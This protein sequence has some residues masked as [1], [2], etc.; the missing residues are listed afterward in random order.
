MYVQFSEEHISILTND[1]GTIRYLY[2][3][4]MNFDSYLVPHKILKMDCKCEYK[5]QN[6]KNIGKIFINLDSAKFS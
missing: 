1:D 5:I 2:A 4:K 3:K 6:S